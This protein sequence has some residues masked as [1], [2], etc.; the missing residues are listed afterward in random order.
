MSYKIEFKNNY[1]TL[2][3]EFKNDT[4]LSA[5]KDIAVYIAYINARMTDN[6]YQLN[7]KGL[8][9]LLNKIDELKK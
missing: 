3:D 7:Y 6:L 2:K 9:I 1:Q 8:E 4:G 5:D